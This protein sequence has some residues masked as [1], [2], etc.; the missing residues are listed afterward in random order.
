MGARVVAMS[1]NLDALK[2][3]AANIPRVNIIQTKGGSE[4]DAKALAKFGTIDA[5]ID[6]S[7]VNTT[8]PRTCLM[9]LKQYGRASLM[10][11]VPTDVPISYLTVVV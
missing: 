10:G 11:V 1:R 4:V 7:P 2:E 8:Y 9:A 6:L 5:C 3:I